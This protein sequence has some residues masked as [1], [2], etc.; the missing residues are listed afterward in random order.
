MELSGVRGG[1]GRAG[2]FS[3]ACSVIWG[4]RA[5]ATV[6]FD[7]VA[8]SCEDRPPP[9]FMSVEARVSRTLAA[10]EL[11]AKHHAALFRFAYRM[12]CRRDVAEDV[13]QDVFIRVM[14]GLER[15]EPRGREA[16]WL[17]TIARRLLFDRLRADSRRPDEENSD[18]DACTAQPG[19]EI[20]AAIGQ[21]LARLAPDER[22]AFLLREIGGLRYDE[23]ADACGVTLAAAR[24]RIYRARVQLRDLLSDSKGHVYVRSSQ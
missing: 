19:Q 17:F 18:P 3:A 9:A 15:Y 6:I 5:A 4:L 2:L 8:P 7:A 20:G 22:E 13:V 12:S 23:I 24:S 11:F 21:A 10:A 1:V 16:A 14:R